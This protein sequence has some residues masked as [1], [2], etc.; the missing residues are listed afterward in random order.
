MC[1]L[2]PEHSQ[3]YHV[4]GTS[5]PRISSRQISVFG[6]KNSHLHH[7]PRLN[8]FQAEDALKKMGENKDK[9]PSYK[10]SV[11]SYVPPP[12]YSERANIDGHSNSSVTNNGSNGNVTSSQNAQGIS[13]SFHSDTDLS[14]FN[15]TVDSFDF[16]QLD[17]VL[18]GVDLSSDV[19]PS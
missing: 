14:D 17:D 4:K 2:P 3:E 10:D 16:Q 5:V 7:Q 15:N 9:P 18:N 19:R 1:Q 11:S 12:A 8:R 13:E 6:I